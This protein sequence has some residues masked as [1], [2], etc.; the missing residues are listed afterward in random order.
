[1]NE[2]TADLPA[3]IARQRPAIVVIGDAILDEWLSGNANRL[4]REAP[5]PVV[6]VERRTVAP[7]GAANTAVNLA[8]LGA[9]VRLVSA[10][11]DDQAGTELIAAL[12]EAG[13]RTDAVRVER[14][15]TVA[16][17]RIVAADQVLLRVDDGEPHPAPVADLAALV[18]GCDAVVLCDYR[19]GPADRRL[20]DAL[21]PLRKDIPL[22]VVDAHRP[23]RWPG[24]RPD[25]VTPNADEAAALLDRPAPA[26]AERADFFAAHRDRLR[27][28]T[29]ADTVVV[30]LDRD[31]AV[32]LSAGEPPYRTWAEPAPESRTAGAGDTFCAALTL[33]RCCGLSPALAVE[34]AQAAADVVVHRPGTAVCTV[35]ALTER[36]AGFQ[37]TALD[38]GALSAVVAEHRG[39]GRRIVFTNGCFDV[40]HRGHIAYLNQA[41]ALGDV[42]VVAL[43]S[44]ASVSR[45]KGRDRPVNPAT[46]RAAVLAALSC[47]DHVTVFDEDTPSQLLRLLR[48]DIYA[49]GGDY[50]PG[51][52]AETEVVGEYGGQVRI[53]DYVADHSTSAVIDRIRG[54]V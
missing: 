20:L 37:G 28:A 54:A 41:K 36:L 12:A 19:S 21:S 5:A 11:G 29:G 4:C 6:D 53:L 33:A 23:D 3:L 14:G 49:K 38:S 7:G 2:L 13:V 31:G 39:A 15:R 16:K 8:A 35:G 18:S 50:S 25:L 47:V 46:D 17:R 51:M 1:M 45:L 24:L 34:L 22:L 10:V 42:L 43:N 40:L 30:T 26:G 52:L 48:P 44:D 32:L 27:D 9:D